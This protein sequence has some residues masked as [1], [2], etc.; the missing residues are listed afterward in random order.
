[1]LGELARRPTA[2]FSSLKTGDNVCMNGGYPHNDCDDIVYM[3]GEGRLKY[4]NICFES[5]G[6]V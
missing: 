3:N 2:P 4:T 6:D 5:H 1:M